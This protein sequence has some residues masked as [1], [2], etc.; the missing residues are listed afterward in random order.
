MAQAYNFAVL[1]EYRFKEYYMNKME[2]YDAVVQGIVK[3]M[4]EES[5]NKGLVVNRIEKYLEHESKRTPKGL[6]G[7]LCAIRESRDSSLERYGR[8]II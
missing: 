5:F 4:G 6:L 8:H 7:L 2:Q 1:S 3:E